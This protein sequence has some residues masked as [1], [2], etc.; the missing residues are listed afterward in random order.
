M[1]VYCVSESESESRSAVSDPLRLYSPGQ[2]TGGGS[3][4]L[5]Q[6]IFPTQGSNLGILHCRQAV[7][8]MFDMDYHIL[9]ITTAL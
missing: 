6:G 5:L 4:S 8:Y 1:T 2:N 7:C 3:C 9:I